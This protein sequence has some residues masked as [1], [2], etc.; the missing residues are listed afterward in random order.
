MEMKHPAIP[1]K[2]KSVH[3]YLD[4][5]LGHLE[6]NVSDVLIKKTKLEYR[7]LYIAWYKSQYKLTHS[8]IHLTLTKEK[9]QDII[10]KSKKRGLK[11]QRFLME[12]IN[13]SLNAS[14]G[15]DIPALRLSIN[16]LRDMIEDYRYE[17]GDTRIDPIIDQLDELETLI[18]D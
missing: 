7:K 12:I 11:L 4:A 3:D 10:S 2:W 6:G 14:I 17:S 5:K 1:F 13:Q 16:Y 8:Q 9:K 18:G 15:I